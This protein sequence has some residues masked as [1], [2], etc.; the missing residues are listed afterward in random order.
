MESYIKRIKGDIENRLGDSRVVS[1]EDENIVVDYV[2]RLN[3]K[4]A[5]GDARERTYRST[6]E[7]LITSIDDGLEVLD[8]P[9]WQRDESENNHKHIAP[10]MLIKRNGLCID[11]IECKDVDKDIDDKEFKDQI[12]R[13]LN[14]ID[15]LIVTNY[16]KF[17]LYINKKKVRTVTIASINKN[18]IIINKEAIEE[19]I[20]LFK[21]FLNRKP[22]QINSVKAL[23]SKM[24][25]LT[26]EMSDIIKDIIDSGELTEVIKD[27]KDNVNKMS[28]V[29]F[30]DKTAQAAIFG[31]FVSCWY[32][33]DISTYNRFTAASK[34]PKNDEY[35]KCIFKHIM[36]E[37]IIDEPYYYLIEEMISTMI[38]LNMTKIKEDANKEKGR[39]DLSVYL[40]DKFMSE[41]DK[42]L[43]KK[44]GIYYTPADLVDPMIKYVHEIL[45]TDLKVE[46]GIANHETIINPITGKLEPLLKL[47]DP[48]GGT[49]SFG[50]GLIRF[51]GDL[52]RNTGE[53]ALFEAYIKEHHIHKFKMFELHIAP[54][55][56]G[57]LNLKNTL[58][59]YN[60][61]LNDNEAFDLI[62]TNT[63]SDDEVVGVFDCVR[64]NA[65]KACYI[66]HIWNRSGVPVYIGNPPWGINSDSHYEEADVYK[67]VS[68]K[69]TG[70]V[71]PKNGLNND[72]INFVRNAEIAIEA[73]GCGMIAFV[74]DNGIIDN[75]SFKLYRKHLCT[76]FNIIYVIDLHG[77][78]HRNKGRAKAKGDEWKKKNS[79]CTSHIRGYKYY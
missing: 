28:S 50:R 12:D 14:C 78:I 76:T 60:V 4:F 65:E 2:K 11:H 75:K 13:Y 73:N 30:A 40:Y 64:E 53:E 66:K 36:E 7:H 56:I 70:G 31:L 41:F 61:R 49:C 58:E 62:C 25:R 22:A 33:K 67:G 17:D 24:V 46:D 23:T 20:S 29:E 44:N 42:P 1:I 72:C 37:S 10:D 8:E 74:M 57:H 68:S 71:E 16:L 43:Q 39:E 15:A 45:K 32:T 38:N 27:V 6:L 55:A 63:L 77:N 3:R 9:K 5:T 34:I 54:I 79:H 18:K 35:V 26:R 52:Y 51:T 59:Q 19:F 21:Q 69:K 48:A 47:L